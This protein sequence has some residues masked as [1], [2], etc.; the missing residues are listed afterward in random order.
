MY[1]TISLCVRGIVFNVMC[2]LADVFLLDTLKAHCHS[3]FYVNAA[4][5]LKMNVYRIES[6]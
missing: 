1:K 3:N 6:T 2:A 5:E 4:S